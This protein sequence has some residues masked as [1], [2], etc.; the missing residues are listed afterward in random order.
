MSEK[1][2]GAMR[3]QDAPPERRGP[4][5]RVERLKGGQ[6]H[7]V[8]I[9]SS[10]LFG[11]FIHYDERAR[12]SEACLE[13]TDTCP[14][15]IALKPQKWRGYLHVGTSRTRPYILELTEEAARLFQELAG[16][17]SSYR[18]LRFKF[19]RTAADNGRIRV[20]QLQ[21]HGDM[22]QCVCECD[23]GPVLHWLWNWKRGR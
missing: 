15:C 1:K 10:K 23:I 9:F 18:G 8:V 7:D 11:V 22:A 19:T 4:D 3:R 2:N 5:I 20:E 14:G 17:V 16:P 6:S 13:D 21:Y 12:R